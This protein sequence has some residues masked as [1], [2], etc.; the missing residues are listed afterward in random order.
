VKGWEREAKK[1]WRGG[2]VTGSQEKTDQGQ[3]HLGGTIAHEM[4]GC[5][6][7]ERL[8]KGEKESTDLAEGHAVHPS[9]IGEERP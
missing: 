8:L 9:T 4:E 5:A 6:M 3:C 7:R 1:G 2:Q